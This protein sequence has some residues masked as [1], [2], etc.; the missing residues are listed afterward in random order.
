MLGPQEDFWIPSLL[1]SEKIQ[2]PMSRC[3]ADYYRTLHTPFVS[4]RT[5]LGTT[6]QRR[7]SQS[8]NLF[9]P[10]GVEGKRR[11]G[12][13]ISKNFTV[14]ELQLLW[15]TS[16]Q[17]K[18]WTGS[19]GEIPHFHRIRTRSSSFHCSLFLDILFPPKKPATHW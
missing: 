6:C 9:N 7:Y 13:E 18:K 16:L 15:P 8:K 10:F 19:A 3:L 11:Y 14:V 5:L 12:D 2:L 17:H 4:H 1:Y